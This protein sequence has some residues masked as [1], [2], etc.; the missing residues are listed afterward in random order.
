MNAKLIIG[1][2]VAATT[3]AG[4][5]LA[6]APSGPGGPGGPGAGGP[7]M[8]RQGM[9]P[10]QGMGP[11]AEFNREDAQAMLDARLAGAK[12][13]LR[14]T[15]EQERLWGP[16]EQAARAMAAERIT[17]MEERRAM[18]E[19]R[20]QGSGER[21]D[22]MQGLER[23]TER[24]SKTADSLKTLTGAM[25]PLWATLDERQ[26]R[27]LPRLLR[28][29]GGMAGGWRMHRGQWGGGHHGH[30]GWNRGDAGP[31]NAPGAPNPAAPNRL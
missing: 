29:S 10:G 1:G 2:L 7:G 24:T 18:R 12:A 25:K 27:L 19:Q 23:M 31:G 26:K 6:Q 5:A 9:G 21:P 30:H 20:R 14:L 13:A 8:N 3:L 15:P 17:R 4:V 11:R 16:V 22:F 28:P